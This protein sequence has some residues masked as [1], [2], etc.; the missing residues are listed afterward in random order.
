[1]SD[2]R[3]CFAAAAGGGVKKKKRA[4]RENAKTPTGSIFL[5][6]FEL[7]VC[8]PPVCYEQAYNKEMNTLR[9]HL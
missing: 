2:Q 7:T 9:S 4:K 3:R 6:A 5:P 8:V 1:L